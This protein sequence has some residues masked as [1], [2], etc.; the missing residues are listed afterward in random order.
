M[1]VVVLFVEAKVLLIVLIWVIVR[2]LTPIITYLFLTIL[3]MA[4][5]S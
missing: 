3:S 4:P 1:I 2:K 5:P